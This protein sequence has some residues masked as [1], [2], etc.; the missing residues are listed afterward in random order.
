MSE[1]RINTKAELLSEID[2][3]W[4]SINEL[5]D[6]LTEPQLT[7]VKDKQG[8]SVKD[9]VVH[10]TAWERSAL[11]FLQGKPRHEGLGVDEATYRSGKDDVINATIQKQRKDQPWPEVLKQFRDNHQQ[12]LKVLEAL[13]DADLQKRYRHYLPQEPGEGDGPTAFRVVAS[14]SGDHY[15]EHLGW[16]ET[17]LKTCR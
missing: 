5:L 12:L 15:A 4:K 17:L 10:L 11:F 2:C 8:W 9:H 6:R 16:I 14:N 3:S 7:Q 1:Q 13:A